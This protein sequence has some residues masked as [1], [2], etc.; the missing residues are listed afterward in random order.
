MSRHLSSLATKKKNDI[1]EGAS[2]EFVEAMC[3]D[4]YLTHLTNLEDEPKNEEVQKCIKWWER[5][6][7]N[8]GIKLTPYFDSK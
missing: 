7:Q 4:V 8:A 6:C 1:F 5:F 3:S 2:K